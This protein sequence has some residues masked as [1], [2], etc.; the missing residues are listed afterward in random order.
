MIQEKIGYKQQILDA[1][2]AAKARNL[3]LIGKLK[4]QV[5]LAD[6]GELSREGEHGRVWTE[7]LQRALEEHE[8]VVIPPSEE[9]YWL[10]GTISI[11][12]NRHL[13]AT[14]ATVRMVPEYPYVMLCNRHVHDGTRA[15][16]D[17]KDRDTNISIHGGTWDE[18][19]TRRSV[20]R[21]HADPESFRGVQTCMLFNNLE[22]LTMT[23]VTFAGATSFCVQVGDL[24]DGVFENFFFLSC[25][26]D[27]L[28]ING[29]CQN[30][31]I[32]NFRGHVGD[33]LVAL[34]MYDWLGSSINYGPCRTV[35][36][37]E[38]HSAPDSKAKAM[39]LQP[40][41]FYYAD[42]TAIDCSLSDMYFRNL[43]GI[44]EYK[45]YFQS[46]PYNEGQ[47]PEG[48]G[49]G[50][51]DNL[52]FENVD[53]ISNRERYP[54]EHPETGYFGMFLLNS[55]IG[56]ISLENI[57]YTKPEGDSPQNYL[58]AVG[59]MSWHRVRNGKD[60]EVFDPYVSGHVE[61]LEMK[62]IFING[63]QATNPEQILKIIVFDDVNHDGFSSGRGSVGRV[64]LDGIRVL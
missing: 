45:L 11:P 23:D 52:F 24:Y 22:H 27:G 58:V 5:S 43:S 64:L 60:E 55:K 63:E 59:P 50:S 16:I 3:D 35:F 26:A 37:E 54:I 30:L 15:P 49:A 7:A 34:N 42:G 41:I 29:N 8:I 33:D 48:G 1:T 53:I 36:C 18:G 19:A 9:I 20:R 25:F 31:Y 44:Y 32:R 40:G 28:H 12:S 6:Y 62:D 13:E 61:T 38:I 14:G 47:K 46:P 17:P 39:R 51:A 4:D 2:L 56:Y 10:D 57:R 21:F